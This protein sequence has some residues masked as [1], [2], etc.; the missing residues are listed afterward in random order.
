MSNP[1]SI[2]AQ[3]VTSVIMFRLDTL[4]I[5]PDKICAEKMRRKDIFIVV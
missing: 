3:K 2:L 4:T 1:F 5:S